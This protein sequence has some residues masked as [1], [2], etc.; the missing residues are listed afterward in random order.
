MKIRR[1]DAC[2]VKTKRRYS[3]KRGWVCFQCLPNE[4]V[5]KYPGQTEK[6]QLRRLELLGGRK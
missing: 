3:D 6:W 2:H 4:I 1:C 5:V